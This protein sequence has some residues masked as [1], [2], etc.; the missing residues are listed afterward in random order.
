MK[1]S[2]LVISTLS[3]VVL[4]G[5]ALVTIPAIAQSDVTKDNMFNNCPRGE[6]TQMMRGNHG[7]GMGSPM[8][9]M[10]GGRHGRFMQGGDVD[11]KLTTERVKDIMAG[12]LA[13]RGNP[14][15]K[16][17][18]VTLDKDGQILAQLVTKDN[19]LIDT[20]KVD[21]KTGERTPIR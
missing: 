3:A 7:G 10:G 8:G 1:R 19:S 16:V 15:V 18:E 12:Q 9:I 5:I 21:P 14:N 6:Y 11:L 20:F 4:G 2:T 17:G 13:W